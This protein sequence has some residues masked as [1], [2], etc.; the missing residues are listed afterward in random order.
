MTLGCLIATNLTRSIS[1]SEYQSASE[2]YQISTW[3]GEDGLPNLSVTS[4][5]QTDEGHLWMGTHRG[6]V[7][8]DGLELQSFSRENVTDLEDESLLRLHFSSQKNLWVASER[9]VYRIQKDKWFKIPLPKNWPGCFSPRSIV[10]TKDGSVF[11]SKGF[12]IWR[13]NNG[14]ATEITPPPVPTSSFDEIS[15]MLFSGE[16]VAANSGG[17]FVRQQENWISCLPG[18]VTLPIRG[19]GYGLGGNALVA[20]AHSIHV[21]QHGK[22]QRSYQ[23]PDELTD[24]LTLV[25]DDQ[26]NIW[27]ASLTA[28]V[29]ILS[30]DSTRK[31]LRLTVEDGLPQ[32]SVASM[33][34]DSD[35]NIWI[36]TVAGGLTRCKRRTI[37]IYGRDRGLTQPF[38]KSIAEIDPGHFWVGTH[39]G[40]LLPFDG[41]HFGPPMTSDPEG[42]Y[43]NAFVLGILP[44]R[45]GTVWVGTTAN[46]LFHSANSILRAVPLPTG[47]G[48]DIHAMLQATDDSIWIGDDGGLTILR[49]GNPPIRAAYANDQPIEAVYCLAEDPSGRIWA[50][51][52]TQGLI[53]VSPQTGNSVEVLIPTNHPVVF[54]M[55]S[56]AVD[57][58]NN[59]WL[60]TVHHGLYRWHDGQLTSLREAG[61]PVTFVGSILST[62]GRLWIGSKSGIYS[63][64]IQ[65]LDTMNQRT[66]SNIVYQQWDMRDGLTTS[67]M[68]VGHSPSICRDHLGGI[69]FP[70]AKGL[71]RIEPN[72][73]RAALR[74][75]SV[76]V[77]EV[78]GD[79]VTLYQRPGAKRATVTHWDSGPSEASAESPHSR[80]I[81][82][83]MHTHRV[84]LHY[85]AVS[86]AEGK[87]IRFQ[88]RLHPNG[89]DWL[90][91]GNSRETELVEL[92]PGTYSFQVRASIDG[93]EWSEPSAPLEVI[94]PT[95]WYQTQAFRVGTPGGFFLILA[96]SVGF[97]KFRRDQRMIEKS[98]HESERAALGAIH[99]LH[100]QIC[101]LDGSGVIL[102]SNRAW[103][104]HSRPVFPNQ[105]QMMPGTSYFNGGIASQHSTV[106]GESPIFDLIHR[107]QSGAN[108]SERLE[109]FS[110]NTETPGWFSIYITQFTIQW[111]RRFL[112]VHEDITSHKNAA[113]A[114][115]EAKSTAEAANRAKSDF[116]ATMSHEIRTPLSGILGFSDLILTS[117]PS[118]DVRQYATTIRR[119]SAGLL[120]IINELLDLSK[121]EAG[122][123]TL[124]PTECHLSDACHEV[125]EVLKPTAAGKGIR[126]HFTESIT[127]VR[128]LADPVRLRQILLNLVGNAVKFTERGEVAVVVDWEVTGKP[129]TPAGR[130]SVRDTGIGI[131]SSKQSQ[132]YQNFFQADASI[133]RRFGGT[134]LGLAICRNLVELMDGEIGFESHLGKGSTF[135][136]TLPAL[137]SRFVEMPALPE[138]RDNVF[139]PNGSSDSTIQTSLD[140]PPHILVVEDNEVN[141]LLVSRQLEILGC[142][143]CVAGNGRMALELNSDR[144]FDLI[145]MD[146]QM[147]EMDGLEVT[148]R[149]RDREQRTDTEA[150]SAKRIPIIML[151]AN[152]MDGDGQ[153]C[154]DAGADGFLGKPHQFEDLRRILEIHLNRKLRP[155]PRMHDG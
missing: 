41:E 42:F 128:V 91:A 147:P 31:P 61:L 144:K 154:L 71:V 73:K 89:S 28:G 103:V 25:E 124:Q 155:I 26:R 106:G 53:R 4:M 153:R 146:W 78:I 99:S 48:L 109:Y 56:L 16:L 8:F 45:D 72:R 112:V 46:S 102:Q 108:H 60:G 119:S 134:G 79:G 51:T 151:T 6:L 150:A 94:A 21:L 27:A 81:V 2:E 97:W 76:N 29:F 86:L 13:L 123:L 47:K 63:V 40:G 7:R 107:V 34:K 77:D 5:A 33:I 122:K 148:A 17:F 55:E 92:G 140:K 66:N 104:E 35:G 74:P 129:K 110:G 141:Q 67:E 70:S 1:A 57:A 43:A 88:R 116:L 68:A 137:E 11:I 20:D 149:I 52:G 126:L 139:H 127:G 114:M 24:S 145:L 87:K 152:V 10:E 62:D 80:S 19:F 85:S 120:T 38:V 37:H 30:S 90:D 133:S 83:P 135:W 98:L 44:A 69:W 101:I 59:A 50:L 49:K 23:I 113:Q 64:S 15:L 65:S 143:V 75:R 54:D 39:G 118:A 96:V 130:V 95:P 111:E 117:T 32:N 12:Q 100:S 3:S 115:T 36:G 125:I 142:N 9:A 136:F 93:G 84:L 14:K 22:L 82:V 121:I 18:N 58:T 105:N 131:D 132:L 138:N